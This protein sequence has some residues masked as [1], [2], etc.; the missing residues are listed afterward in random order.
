MKYY[1]FTLIFLLFV[2]NSFSED[3]KKFIREGN[4]LFKGKKFNEAEIQ[5][6][7]ALDIDKSHI[8]TFNLGDALYKTR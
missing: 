4:E 8:S 7:K 2:A 6:R 5:Y 1:I 3:S